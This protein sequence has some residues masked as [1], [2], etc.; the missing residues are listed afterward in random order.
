[1]PSIPPAGVTPL[2]AFSQPSVAPQVAPPAILADSI[3]PQTGDFA[4]LVESAELADAFALDALLIERATGAV[5]RDFGNR[6]REITHVEPDAALVIDSMTRQAFADA[7][8]AG[9]AR[10][11]RTAIEQDAGDPSQLN[12]VVEYRD[13]L[14]PRDSA[15]RRLVYPL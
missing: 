3:D 8:R 15:K 4:S 5:V 10:L 2:S 11:E 12:V 6:Y 14:A 13:L 9:V 7:E 1:M